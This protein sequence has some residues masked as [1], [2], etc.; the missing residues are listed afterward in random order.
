MMLDKG[1]L[2]LQLRFFVHNGDDGRSHLTVHLSGVTFAHGCGGLSATLD[3]YR[4]G[5]TK[6][7]ISPF[8]AAGRGGSV[9]RAH[10]SS[11]KVSSSIF[12]KKNKYPI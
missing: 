1:I 4:M 3:G 11:S 5:S 6:G 2:S 8:S 9:L 12:K 7:Q 10:V